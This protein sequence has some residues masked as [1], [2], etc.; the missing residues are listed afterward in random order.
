MKATKTN[1]GQFIIIAV[2]LVAIMIVAIGAIMHNAVT[3]YRSEPWEEYTTLV[4][5]IELNS[6]HLVELSHDPA[7]FE[8]NFNEWQSDLTRL[9]PGVGIKLSYTGNHPYVTFMLNITSVG[10]EGYKFSAE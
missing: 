7:E 2:L 4:S 8:N 3:Y 6:Q 5:N 9:Y 10:L 1:R